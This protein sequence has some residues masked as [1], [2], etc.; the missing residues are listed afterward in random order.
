MRLGAGTMAT[1]AGGLSIE[2]WL[3]LNREIEALTRAG[4]PL[5]AGLTAA[6][7]GLGGQVGEIS[8]RLAARLERGES[9]EKALAAER[10]TLPPLYAAV[11]EA[12]VRSGRLSSALEAMTAHLEEYLELRRSVVVA[13]LYPMFLVLMAYVLFVGFVLVVVPVF[14]DTFESMRV[15]GLA[16]L[17]ALSSLGQTA[18][19][20]WVPILPVVILLLGLAWVLMGRSNLMGATWTRRAIR[21]IPWAGGLMTDSAASSFAGL[22]ALLVGHDVPLDEAL[23]LA[24]AASG[25]PRIISESN[26]LAKQLRLG[27]V[28]P[29]LEAVARPGGLPALLG[30]MLVTGYRRGAV[31][32]A[33]AHASEVYRRRA[34]GR[35]QALRTY[36]PILLVAV[37]GGVAVLAYTLLLFWPL[38]NLFRELSLAY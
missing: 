24:G 29:A 6:G 21:L 36:L 25:E 14:Q 33:M 2:G 26:A 31:V 22:L 27:Q 28:D 30:W 32:A 20:L 37:I 18:W 15:P 12:G 7:E 4:L 34:L 19:W 11:V 8:Q 23:E 38:T 1:G 9:I 13:L 10:S 16:W 35:A 17:D 5:E 3:A